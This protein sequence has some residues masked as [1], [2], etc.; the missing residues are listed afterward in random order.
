MPH[1]RTGKDGRFQFR[2]AQPGAC[3]V[4]AYANGYSKVSLD[5]VVAVE[6]EAVE[7]PRI[8][9]TQGIVIKG[10]VRTT[11]GT[12]VPPGMRVS[13][14]E[15]PEASEWTGANVADD[16]SWQITAASI[17]PGTWTV[18]VSKHIVALLGGTGG[19]QVPLATAQVDL[20]AGA[21]KTVTLDIE[22]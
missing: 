21:T 18:S 10:L 14:Q 3:V 12:P 2:H 9:L 4:T 6:G 11:N 22:P 15:S 20:V 1:V 5:A 7:V 17:K 13:L 8:E 19:S 16:G